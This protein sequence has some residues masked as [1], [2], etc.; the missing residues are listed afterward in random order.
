MKII[1]LEI[2]DKE[3]NVLVARTEEEKE[4]GLQDV[5]EL[6]D[7]EGMLFIYSEPQTLE[8]WMHDTEIPLDIIFI[9]ENWEVKS[10]QQGKPFDDTILSCDDVQY[11][12][13]LNQ[14]SGVKEGDEID[15]EDDELNPGRELQS[16]YMEI[17]G[18]DGKVQAEIVGGER[19]FSIKNVST[20]VKMARR[21]QATKKESDYKRLGKK[22]FEY[23]SV[24]DSNNPEYVNSSKEIDENKKGE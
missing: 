19:I 8:F 24:Q 4:R 9:D 12:L 23:L 7:N 13:E 16:K 14:N 10:V 1:K 20:L 2:N 3:Y 18:P 6:D 11:V 17:Y 5:I 21:A 15:V 22:I